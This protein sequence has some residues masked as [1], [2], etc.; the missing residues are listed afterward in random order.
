MKKRNVRGRDV[1]RFG[2]Y[3][4]Q[5]YKN[6]HGLSVFA[7]ITASFIELLALKVSKQEAMTG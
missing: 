4:R 2:I 3:I 6:L 5:M 7:T 1:R